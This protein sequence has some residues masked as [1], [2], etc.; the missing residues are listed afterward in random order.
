MLTVY[1]I[2]ACL[3]DLSLAFIVLL[4]IIVIVAPFIFD[5]TYTLGLYCYSACFMHC[6]GWGDKGYYLAFG[7]SSALLM[8]KKV[9]IALKEKQAV[10]QTVKISVLWLSIAVIYTAY[11]LIVNGIEWRRTGIGLDMLQ[12]C[13]LAFLIRKTVDYKKA[14]VCLWLGIIASFS[15]AYIFCME[16]ARHEFIKGFIEYRFGAFFNNENTMAVYCT[17]CS[18]C[19]IALILSGRIKEKIYI[20]CPFVTTMIGL[21]VMSKAFIVINIALYFAWI[22]IGFIKAKKKLYHAI[23]VFSGLVIAVILCIVYKDKV[24]VILNRFYGGSME[25]FWDHLTTGRVDIWKEYIAN[26]L[27][28]PRTILFGNGFTAPKI[29]SG[30]YE[31]NVYIAFLN[32]YGILGSALLVFAAIYTVKQ[33][34]AMERNFAAYI[35]FILFLFNGLSSNL[36]GTLCTCLPWL[37]AVSIFSFSPQREER[38]RGSLESERIE[39]KIEI[40]Q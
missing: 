11:T 31:H 12:T 13:V 4:Y 14:L 25:N 7:V 22:I 37:L 38:L 5:D 23:F 39:E 33:N 20:A 34:C 35:P 15:I 40:G 28:S 9:V 24:A 32:Q 10:A 36:S 26:W 8:V 17:F 3:S 27:S 6:F 1:T 29:S 21:F 19:F 18:S 2:F 30:Y 16:G